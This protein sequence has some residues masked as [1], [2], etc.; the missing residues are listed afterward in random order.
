MSTKAMSVHH[1][2]DNN[3]CQWIPTTPPT[4]VEHRRLAGQTADRYGVPAHVETAAAWTTWP[5]IFR[6]AM[7]S[8]SKPNAGI[9]W[10]MHYLGDGGAN[11]ASPDRRGHRRPIP[12][13][14]PASTSTTA[15]TG[16][17]QVCGCRHH[18]ARCGDPAARASSPTPPLIH[19]T[20]YRLSC[21]PP[22]I[23]ITLFSTQ[24]EK[25]M[26]TQDTKLALIATFDSDS[27]TAHCANPR[28]RWTRGLAAHC[29]H[30]VWNAR[31]CRLRQSPA[32]S[33]HPDAAGAPTAGGR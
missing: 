32:P 25:T 19:N 12:A 9:L 28:S 27:A 11:H 14:S 31:L 23:I 15:A 20:D 5:R 18:A 7:P 8:S 6:T 4:P 30:S 10:M 13:R 1:A 2:V 29:R 16:M 17:R 22:G 3:E 33:A 21:R 26:N 24:K